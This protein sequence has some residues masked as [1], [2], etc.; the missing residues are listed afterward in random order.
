MILTL[1]AVGALVLGIIILVIGI[2][3][4][5]VSNNAV[6]GV[7]AII[8]L[9]GGGMFSAF[10]L[11]DIAVNQ[12]PTTQYNLQLEYEETYNTLIASLK[13]D[14]NNVVI[15]AD[16]VAEYNIK[17]KK[18]YSL[19]ESPWTNWLQPIINTELKTINLED[20]LN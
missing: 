18:H 16:K 11:F 13:A 3:I 2:K 17:V 19:L 14:K 7:I 10:F 5:Y 15:L 6:I 20:Y 9:I 12:L 8:L 4:E 1:I